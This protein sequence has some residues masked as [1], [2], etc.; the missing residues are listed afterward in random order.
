[1]D[2]RKEK[3]KRLAA[4]YMGVVSRLQALHRQSKTRAIAYSKLSL[5]EQ[6]PR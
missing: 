2:S 3:L 5:Q 1:M 6:I 4:D